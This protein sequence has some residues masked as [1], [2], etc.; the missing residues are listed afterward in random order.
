MT[1]EYSGEQHVEAAAPAEAIEETS[2]AQESA[3]SQKVP[4][5][6]LQQ[7]RAQRQQ[8]QDE[9]KMIKDHMALMQAQ[10][11][12]PRREE[13]KQFDGLED[14]DVLT[15]GEFKKALTAKEQQYNMSLQELKM[16]QKHPDYQEVLTRYLPKVLES[17]PSLRNA[18]QQSQD[19]ELA[20]YLAKNSDAYKADNRQTKRSKE[21]EKMLQNAQQPGS[22]SSVGGSSTQSS[23]KNWKQMSDQEFMSQVH[24]NL[25]YV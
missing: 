6:A 4:L 14:D 3:E 7:E 5:D 24:K 2:Y 17:N 18:L 9:L 25:G 19:Y 21:A 11:Q 12:Q 22:L 10:Q 13:P 8:L 1:E 20:Y 16:A 15:V 23:V